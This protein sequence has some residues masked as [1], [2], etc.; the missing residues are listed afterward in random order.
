MNISLNN[1]HASKRSANLE[2]GLTFESVGVFFMEK[3]NIY[4]PT[5]LEVAECDYQIEDFEIRQEYEDYRCQRGEITDAQRDF[6]KDEHKMKVIY[7][8]R[9]KELA[10]KS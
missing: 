10:K 6:L 4:K 9:C 2:P 3:I 5:K 8:K 7:F 1:T